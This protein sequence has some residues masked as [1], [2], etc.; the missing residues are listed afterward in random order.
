MG[1]NNNSANGARGHTCGIRR[2]L[3]CKKIPMTDPDVR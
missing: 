3:T 1:V 2:F